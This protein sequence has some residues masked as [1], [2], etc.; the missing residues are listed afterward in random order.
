MVKQSKQSNSK[1]NFMQ[2]VFFEKG[3]RCTMGGKAPE[4]AEF[5]KIFVLKVTLQSAS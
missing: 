5:S 2:Y 3:I 1:Y 4:A